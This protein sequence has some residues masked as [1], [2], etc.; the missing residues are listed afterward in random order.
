MTPSRVIIGGTL[1]AADNYKAIIQSF[2][3]PQ[4]EFIE[5]GSSEA[6]LIK[7]ASNNYLA[8]RVAFFN[9]LDTLCLNANLDTEKVISGICSDDRIGVHYNNPSFGFGGYCLP[10]DNKQLINQAYPENN[11]LLKSIN[12]SNTERKL[13]I[14][15]NIASK[16]VKSVGVHRIIMNNNS[17]NFRES[18]IIDIIN[19]LKETGIKIYIFEPLLETNTFEGCEVLDNFQVFYDKSEVIITNRFDKILRKGDKKV[20]SRDI[21]NNG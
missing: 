15:K 11:S 5:C 19:H 18:A 9:E 16:G 1:G 13:S 7:L 10:K 4:N 17:Q 21:Y 14:S 6:E 2:L 12:K 20:Y 8:M 3:G